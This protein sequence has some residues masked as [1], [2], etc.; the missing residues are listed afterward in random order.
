MSAFEKFT[1]GVMSVLDGSLLT[2]LREI[3]GRLDQVG[4]DTNAVHVGNNRVLMRAMVAGANIAFLL[5]ADDRLLTP[6][7][8]VSG[9]Y[10]TELTDF[11]LRHLKPDSHC[12]DVGANFGYYTCLMSRF[13]PAGRIVAI[14]V[15]ADVCALARDNIAI[16]GFNHIAE[17]VH[18]AASDSSK[19]L[20]LHRR[21][22]RSGNTSVARMPEEFLAQHG[23][24]ASQ[25]FEVAGMRIDDLLPRF[26][27]RVDFI[28]I[29]VEGAE[30]LALRGARETIERNPHLTIVMEWSPGQI[31]EAGFDVPAFLTELEERGLRITRTTGEVLS[32]DDLLAAPYLTGVVIRRR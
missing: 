29:D 30:P 16:N 22:T 5:E 3:K 26:D 32:R 9:R 23:E 18:A 10:E 31:R 20:T 27:G 11:F 7:F 28:K 6:W 1:R 15:D 13:C 17:A 19:P 2:E 12:I 24:A 14:E 4:Y 21:H 25:P 8:I